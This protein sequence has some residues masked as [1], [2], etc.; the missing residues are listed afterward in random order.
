MKIGKIEITSVMI[1]LICMKLFLT[2]PRELLSSAGNGAWMASLFITAAALFIFYLTSKIYRTNKTV[3][4]IADEIGGKWFKVITGII[5][6]TVIGFNLTFTLRI[7]P[8]SVR[9]ILLHNTPMTVIIT[10]LCVGIGLGTYNGIE[11]I[12]RIASFFLPVAAAVMIF[13]VVLLVPHFNAKNIAPIL[14]KGYKSIFLDSFNG[15]ALFS[16]L[17]I[18]NLLLPMC[19]NK[20]VAFKSGIKAILISGAAMT[21]ILIALGL[22]YPRQFSENF[23]MPVYQLTRLVSIGDFFSRVEAFFEFLWSIAMFLYT[24][25]YI[26]ILCYIWKETFNLK[27]YKPLVAPIIAICAAISY[28]SESLMDTLNLYSQSYLYIYIITAVFPIFYGTLERIRNK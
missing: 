26:Y 2:F 13:F 23:I 1:N 5:L 20:D 16:D 17:I 24:S 6:F 27:Y 9:I 21:V 12:S 4:D 25:M 7:F 22:V 18:L 8:E 11:S 10:L 19:K 14:G 3:L 15:I 28:M